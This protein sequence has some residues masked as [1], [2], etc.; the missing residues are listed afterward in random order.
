RE[1]SAVF[2]CRATIVS[3]RTDAPLSPPIAPVPPISAY[4]LLKM[5]STAIAVASRQ[6]AILNPMHAARGGQHEQIVSATGMEVS[7]MLHRMRCAWV[8]AALASTA[9]RT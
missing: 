3:L 6:P 9:A 8:A 7:L 1:E 4:R 2:A 5:A